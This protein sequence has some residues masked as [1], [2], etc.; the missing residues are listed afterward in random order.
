MPRYVFRE[1]EPLRLKAGKEA[2]AQRIGEALEALTA[3]AEGELAPKAVVDAARS[4]S[5]PLHAHFEWDD[6]IAAE[7]HRLEQARHIIRIVR[8]VDEDA[9]EGNTRAFLSVSDKGG[10]SYRPMG[11][12][13]QSV[14]LQAAVLRAAARDL[15]AFQRRYRDLTDVCA[16]VTRAKDALSKRMDQGTRRAA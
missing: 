16:I 11:D 5:H 7:A 15:D 14:D 13:K 3:L 4:A 2:D 10:T 12:V 6:A 8:V 9:S 1:D